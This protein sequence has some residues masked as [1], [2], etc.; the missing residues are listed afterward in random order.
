MNQVA[1]LE[2]LAALRDNGVLTEEE[3][4]KAK[5][6]IVSHLTDPNKAPL[7]MKPWGIYVTL[8]ALAG[9][10]LITYS[11][12]SNYHIEANAVV[13]VLNPFFLFVLPLGLYWLY[14]SGQFNSL[15]PTAA[16]AERVSL[17][18]DE[19]STR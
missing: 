16:Q 18:R 2:K 15:T 17:L 7:W 6:R 8:I 11:N 4:S 19:R 9:C 12:W 13:F 3:F 10:S 14:R 5:A 1:D